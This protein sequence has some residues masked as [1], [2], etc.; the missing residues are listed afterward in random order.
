MR[1]FTHAITI[2]VA[3]QT[4]P[5]AV[6]A[7]IERRAVERDSLAN[8]SLTG[9][10]LQL[11]DLPHIDARGGFDLQD[12]NLQV[13]LLQDGVIARNSLGQVLHAGVHLGDGA[14]VLLHV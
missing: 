3:S 10:T 13:E 1:A 6:S 5:V 11:I 4:Q 7:S 9:T 2:E 12:L 8:S 14:L